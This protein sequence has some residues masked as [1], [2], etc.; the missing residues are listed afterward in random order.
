MSEDNATRRS[1]LK[2]A[3][4]AAVGVVGL[5][6]MTGSAAANKD[7]TIEFRVADGDGDADYSCEVPDE[8][9]DCNG[10]LEQGD[11]KTEKDGYMKIEGH[12]DN[13]WEDIIQFNDSL[14]SNHFDWTVND[15][16]RVVVDSSIEHEAH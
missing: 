5:A 10:T 1:M 11:S 8:S 7:H 6:G 12:V 15:P 4:V 13:G 2:R 14:D 16:M 3:G 9:P